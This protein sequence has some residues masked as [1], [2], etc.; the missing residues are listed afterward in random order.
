MSRAVIL[1][2]VLFSAL[3][4][5]AE[6]VGVFISANSPDPT[7]TR[8]KVIELLTGRSSTMADNHRV[9]LVL[10]HGNAG[11]EAV[12]HFVS[13]DVSRLL[14][15][16]KRL[17]FGSGGSMPLTAPDDL[18]AIVLAARTPQALMPWSGPIPSNLPA[19]L[20]FI[21]TP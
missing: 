21:P 14:R 5:G 2:A 1:L 3:A 19:Q 8:D 20:R 10:S 18:A 12:Q 11:S 9:T 7:L 16:W 15:G 6:N 4:W 13:R 17:V